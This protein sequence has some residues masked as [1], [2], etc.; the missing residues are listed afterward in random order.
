MEN[1]DLRYEI[2]EKE[3]F[4]VAKRELSK[5]PK[6][7]EYHN[8]DHYEDVINVASRIATSEGIESR[9]NEF[10]LLKTAALL[11]DI[12]LLFT[13]KD[14]EEKGGLFAKSLLPIYEYSPEEIETISG[15]ILST[16][17]P[18]SPKTKLEG[19][20]CDADLDNLGR[21][22]FFEKGELV[23]K[24]LEN[25]GIKMSDEQWFTNTHNLIKNHVY[26]TASQRALRDEGKERNIKKLIEILDSLKISVR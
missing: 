25:Y 2:L 8:T 19:I 11:H 13:Y 1:R 3:I 16:K 23:R 7:L 14:H 6:K 15:M 21:E 18:Q 20:I 5:L 17:L 12:G 24:E 10:N 22:D 9:S 4:R 26:H